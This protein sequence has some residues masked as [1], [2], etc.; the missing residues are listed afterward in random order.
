MRPPTDA[1]REVLRDHAAPRWIWWV[2]GA[3]IGILVA[4]EVPVILWMADPT[5]VLRVQA[6]NGSAVIAGGLVWCVLMTL[7]FFW[8]MKRMNV[9]LLVSNMDLEKRARETFARVDRL[10]T[11]MQKRIDGGVLERIE[12]HLEAVRRR[13]DRDTAPLGIRKRRD[14]KAEIFHGVDPAPGGADV[15]KGSAGSDAQIPMAGRDPGGAL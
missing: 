3:F 6:L 1:E 9:R 13:V 4:I 11:D 14:E 2:F 8:P 5:A 10:M 15:P 12:G 7:V